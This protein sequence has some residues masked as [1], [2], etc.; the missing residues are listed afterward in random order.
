[1]YQLNVWQSK[2][3]RSIMKA[4]SINIYY[5]KSYLGNNQVR[6][7]LYN[8]HL[9][10]VC[11]CSSKYFPFIIILPPIL[12]DGIWSTDSLRWA[13]RSQNSFSVTLFHGNTKHHTQ[14]RKT[15]S[16]SWELGWEWKPDLAFFLDGR[17][18]PTGTKKKG[19]QMRWMRKWTESKGKRR[20]TETQN[21]SGMPTLVLCLSLKSGGALSIGKKQP[22]F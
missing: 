11:L 15:G 9:P 13:P 21:L 14:M 1:M 4:Q 5:E 17:M 3:Y 22:T 20:K 12:W 18:V 19:K 8:D 6:S 10:T 2:H 7:Y 16:L